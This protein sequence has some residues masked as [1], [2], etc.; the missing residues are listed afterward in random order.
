[1]RTFDRY[2]LRNDAE[3]RKLYEAGVPQSKI[4][5]HYGATVNAVYN[6]AR[7]LGFGP[8]P[9]GAKPQET[10]VPTISEV[11]YAKTDP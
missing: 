7:K 11:L 3:F 6:K 1:M 4:A 10:Y 9:N 8:R 5:Q 2:K